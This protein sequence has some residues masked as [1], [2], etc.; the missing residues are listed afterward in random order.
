MSAQ[1]NVGKG[2]TCIFSF[3]KHYVAVVFKKYVEEE[4]EQIKAIE[5]NIA[6]AKEKTPDN[7]LIG[8][9]ERALPLLKNLLGDIKVVQQRFEAMPTCD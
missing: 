6:E 5:K 7:Q 8:M 1:E 9:T 3:E 2:C 4:E